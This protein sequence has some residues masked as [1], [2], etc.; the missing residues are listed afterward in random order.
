[1]PIRAPLRAL[2]DASLLARRKVLNCL[3]A[4]ECPA[5]NCAAGEVAYKSPY[6]S[7]QKCCAECIL[8]DEVFE[9]EV[10]DYQQATEHWRRAQEE[11]DRE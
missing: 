3:T 10:R 4:E 11:Q 9:R 6:L 1:M 5:L 2:A 7:V 8:A